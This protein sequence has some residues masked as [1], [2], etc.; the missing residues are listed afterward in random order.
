MTRVLRMS[1]QTAGGRTVSI[2]L[3]EPVD[4]L[5]AADVDSVMDKVVTGNIFSTASG[6]IAAKLR[7]EVIE[8]SV[9][10]LLD[11]A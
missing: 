4:P 11:F 8:T 1:F 10:T 9:D 5:N 2:S 6:D 7:A 3:R